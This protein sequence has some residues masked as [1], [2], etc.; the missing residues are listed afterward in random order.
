MP[1]CIGEIAFC[2]LAANFG[3]E[4]RR[5]PGR[6]HICRRSCRPVSRTAF[7][8]TIHDPASYA[9][10]QVLR[11]CKRGGVQN[12]FQKRPSIEEVVQLLGAL[13]F[14]SFEVFSTEVC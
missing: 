1:I 3:R 6:V 11:S 14:S 7:A 5:A 13:I 4:H 10:G 12:G 9:V 2:Q 8:V